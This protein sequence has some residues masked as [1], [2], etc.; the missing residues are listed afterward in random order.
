ML[1]LGHTVLSF[2][3]CSLPPSTET[4]SNTHPPTTGLT[5]LVAFCH[6]LVHVLDIQV[7]LPCHGLKSVSTE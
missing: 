5:S 2:L 1:N 6:N 3:S 4:L 7:W